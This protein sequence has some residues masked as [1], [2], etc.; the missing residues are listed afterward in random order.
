[1]GNAIGVIRQKGIILLDITIS[2]I[3]FYK[4]I[5]FATGECDFF[6]A[7]MLPLSKKNGPFQ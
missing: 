6:L 1:M 4:E 3:D 5:T 2:L 7:D